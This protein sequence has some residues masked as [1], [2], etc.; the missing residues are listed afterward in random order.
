[1][2]AFIVII[3]VSLQK[4]PPMIFQEKKIKKLTLFDARV[5]PFLIISAGFG[6]SNAALVQTSSF[7][8][9]DIITPLFRELYSSC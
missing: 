8:F 9:Q 6:I 2:G 3:F 1:M 4:T 5:W 7:F